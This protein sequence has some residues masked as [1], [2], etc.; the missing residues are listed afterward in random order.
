[1]ECFFSPNL[2]SSFPSLLGL[3]LFSSCSISLT[4]RPP[5]VH[6]LA[7]KT[8]LQKHRIPYCEIVRCVGRWAG[9]LGTLSSL[10]LD[11][12]LSLRTLPL[13]CVVLSALLLL[14]P[15]PTPPLQR[16]ESCSATA[17]RRRRRRASSLLP[18][19]AS[20]IL[21]QRLALFGSQCKISLSVCVSV[22]SSSISD[23]KRME[24]DEIRFSN[25]YPPVVRGE[26]DGEKRERERER[27]ARHR[28]L[29]AMERE[30]ERLSET[31]FAL[32]G[33]WVLFLRRP[34]L[35]LCPR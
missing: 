27:D 16:T 23:L 2:S 34:Q 17:R 19:P 11:L 15:L 14:L 13:G 30:R 26:R 33:L 21:R 22:S 31:L 8:I 35:R 5:D 18:L 9:H 32:V 3:L 24:K 10:P 1:M 6:L 20:S 4:A 25:D 12:S 7:L 28:K 29:Q